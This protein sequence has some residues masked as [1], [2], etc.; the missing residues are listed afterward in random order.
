MTALIKKLW[1]ISWDIWDN[2]NEFLHKTQIAADLS[3]AVSLDKAI[4]EECRLGSRGLP[5]LVRTTFP[6]KLR[7]ESQLH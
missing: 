4:R 7:N 1:Q 6:K 5:V 3:G 2:R